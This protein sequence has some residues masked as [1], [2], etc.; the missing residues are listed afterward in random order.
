M[1][2]FVK[3]RRR[4]VNGKYVT[5]YEYKYTT[6]EYR[7]GLFGT[8]RKVD[9]Q[10]VRWVDEE[11]YRHLKRQSRQKGVDVMSGQ[12]FEIFCAEHLLKQGFKSVQTTSISGDY[13]ADLVAY[14]KRG[15]K[16]VFQ[17]KRYSNTVGVKAIQE[18]NTAKNH[19][20]AT[21]AAV[22]TNSKFTRNA[23]RLAMENDIE[24]FEM[25]SD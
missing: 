18:V 25:L 11:T 12:E 1:L 23:K 9:V 3:S 21:K 6:K 7:K 16:W 4:K 20:G 13:G 2:L 22:M 17:C 8:T 14:D 5:Q 19:Y 15:N 24:L 10:K